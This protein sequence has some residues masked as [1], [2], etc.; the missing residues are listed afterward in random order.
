MRPHPNR[1]YDPHIGGDHGFV[2]WV[3]VVVDE[4]TL[5]ATAEGAGSGME[6]W[7]PLLE[8]CGGDDWEWTVHTKAWADEWKENKQFPFLQM[9]PALANARSPIDNSTLWAK[10]HLSPWPSWHGHQTVP[11]TDSAGIAAPW[12]VP[13]SGLLPKGGSKTYA[14][15]LTMAAGN[16]RT[17]NDALFVF[18]R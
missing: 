7:R 1:R 8:G 18:L 15:R 14:V 12:N 13:T 3:R 2:E 6:G 9:D 11:I 10:P 16:P 5:M 17:R 4:Q